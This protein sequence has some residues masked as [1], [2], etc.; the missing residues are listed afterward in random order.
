MHIING[1]APGQSAPGRSKSGY[2]ERKSAWL[3]AAEADFDYQPRDERSLPAADEPVN[4]APKP[5]EP[6]K[7][8][9]T[10]RAQFGLKGYTLTRSRRVPDGRITYIVERRTGPR[11]FTHLHDLQAFLNQ[12]ME[13]AI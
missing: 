5:P 9:A 12:V 10:M 3:G 11:H 1:D 6:P 7:D 2:Q 4:E 8:F 13:A